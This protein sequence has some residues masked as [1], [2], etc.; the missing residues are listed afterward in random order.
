MCTVLL[1]EKTREN[2]LIF[3][4]TWGNLNASK[5]C[6]WHREV[7]PVDSYEDS[8][9]TTGTGLRTVVRTLK[10]IIKIRTKQTQECSFTFTEV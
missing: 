6:L 1:L 7:P 4:V 10:Y 8:T 9:K 2:N 5:A 3:V